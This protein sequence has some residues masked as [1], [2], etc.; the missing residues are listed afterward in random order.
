MRRRKR[1]RRRTSTMKKMKKRRRTSIP[2]MLLAKSAR[3]RTNDWAS[4][5]GRRASK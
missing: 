3:A 5:T 4:K 1:R 2:A